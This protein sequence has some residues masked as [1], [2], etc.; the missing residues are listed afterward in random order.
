MKMPCSVSRKKN[1][2]ASNGRVEPIQEK[3]LGRRSTCGLNRSAK[4]SRQREL[5]PSATTTRSALRMAG[6][7]GEISR[8]YSISTPGERARRPRIFTSVPR[9]QLGWP[10]QPGHDAREPHHNYFKPKASTSQA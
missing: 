8:W 4:V 10:G 5:M 3:K 2:K 7:S 1:V 6:A 9:E